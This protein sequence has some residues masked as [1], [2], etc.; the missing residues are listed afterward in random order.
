MPSSRDATY[1]L[2][3]HSSRS[4]ECTEARPEGG[5]C[6]LGALAGMI[7][8]AVRGAVP[9][10]GW[11]GAGSEGLGVRMAV[12]FVQELLQVAMFLYP[13]RCCVSEPHQP[14]CH[15]RGTGQP[16]SRSGHPPRRSCHQERRRPAYQAMPVRTVEFGQR[17]ACQAH[18]SKWCQHQG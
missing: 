11:V 1:T 12:P 4:T 2:P 6:G 15:W 13:Q 7:G 10:G 8:S 3:E 16:S 14:L 5:S 18:T 17:L 9:A